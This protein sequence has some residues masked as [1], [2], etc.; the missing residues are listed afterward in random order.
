MRACSLRFPGPRAGGL[1]KASVAVPPPSAAWGC[2]QRMVRPVSTMKGAYPSAAGLTSHRAVRCHR[3]VQR[4]VQTPP[5]GPCGA[6]RLGVAPLVN[7][8]REGHLR[9]SGSLRS[10]HL[11]SPLRAPSRLPSFSLR[12][13]RIECDAAQGGVRGDAGC[14]RRQKAASERSRVLAGR[15]SGRRWAGR[16]WGQSRLAG[17]PGASAGIGRFRRAAAT[18]RG[19]GRSDQSGTVRSGKCPRPGREATFFARGGR[20]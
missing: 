16:L 10:R 8:T 3:V 14:P 17:R 1:P 7:R 5:S 19:P 4:S 13:L 15:S 9:L 2:P 11:L 12:T 18:G 6:L 20:K